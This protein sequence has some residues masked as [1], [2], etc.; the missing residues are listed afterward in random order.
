MARQLGSLRGGL[1]RMENWLGHRGRAD[2]APCDRNVL[3]PSF[4]R[5]VRDSRTV[6]ELAEDL[7]TEIDLP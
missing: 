6:A 3:S 1:G 7:L 4:Q 2:L 5:L